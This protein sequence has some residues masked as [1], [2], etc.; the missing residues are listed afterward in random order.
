MSELEFNPNE[1]VEK[2]AELAGRKL[3][4]RAFKDISYCSNPKADIQKLNFFVP[5]VYYEGKEINGYGLTNAPI[6]MPN[7]VGGYME[8]PKD[9]P[10]LDR[11]GNPNSVFEA[12]CHGYVVVSAGIRGRNTGSVSYEFFEGGKAEAEGKE[13]TACGKAPAFIV[14]MKAAIRYLR[15]NRNNIP[16]YTDYINTNGT[17]AGGALS[18]LTGSSGNCEEYEPYLQEIGAAEEKDNIFAAS[19][20]CPI[21]NLENADAAYEWQ[22]N[23]EH[24]VY[25]R[26]FKKVDNKVV[27]QENI[28][29]LSEE[30]I[31]LSNE[32]KD[33]FSNYVNSLHLTKDGQQLTLDENGEGSFLDYIKSELV[34]SSKT[35]AKYRSKAEERSYLEAADYFDGD[36][37]NWDKFVAAQTRMKAVPA[38]DDLNLNSPENEEFGDE[39]VKA[40]HFT[41]TSGKYGSGEAADSAVIKMMNPMD[42]IAGGEGAKHWRIRHGSF[43]R[44]TSLAIPFIFERKLADL[45]YDVDFALP[46]GM[47]HSGDYDLDDLF[48]WIDQKVKED[49]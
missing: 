44:D 5:K 15:L 11:R 20:Y 40:R 45:G 1:Y 43:D 36:E 4:Y 39:N 24:L 17:S 42:M 47:P 27:A 28:T 26:R 25:G 7:T 13:G 8:G 21:I 32:L 14:D 3:T 38:F 10:G 49:I 29:T 16:G 35:A 22:F 23:K 18:A 30:Q 34:K 48:A 46:W 9:E 41:A 33:S 31:K 19:C 6:F 37:I 12:L 2:E